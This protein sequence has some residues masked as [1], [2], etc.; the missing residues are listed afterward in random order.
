V[1]PN[2]SS[3]LPRFA[4]NRPVTVVVV[5]FATIVVGLIALK[6][7]PVELF[8][9]GFEAPFL[10]AWT[11]YRD[12]NPQEI[13]E[14]IAK[15]IEEI[16]QTISGLKS[17]ETSSQSQGVWTFLRFNRGTD[18]DVAYAQFRDRMDRVK[19]ELPDGIDRIYLRKFGEN[20]PDI[21]WIVIIIEG[22]VDDPYFLVE[23]Y[24]QRPLLKVDGVASVE[25][26]GAFEK[27]ILIYF[28][29]SKVERHQV[30]LNTVIGKLRTDN[31][32]MSSGFVKDGERK[33]YVRTNSKF[34]SLEAI[35]NIPVKGSN[36]RLSDIADVRYDVPERNWRNR[37][38]G[39]TG[40]S[41]SI[42]KESTANTVAL[43]AAAVKVL[44]EDIIP[45]PA[46]KNLSFNVLFNQ[47]D[48][49]LE[50][51]S[52]LENAAMWGGIFAFLI[53]FFFLRRVRMTLIVTL[54]IPISVMIAMI[55]IYFIDWSLN[56][57]TMMG[58][59]I[60][61][62]MVVDNAIVILEN[63]YR[64][65]TDGSSPR[66]AALFGASEVSLAITMAT[67]TTIAVF[68]PMIVLNSNVGFSFYMLR[69]G[70]P[71]IVA[72]VASLFV[73]LVII[74]LATTKVHSKR[75]VKESRLI[76]WTLGRYENTLRWVMN[77][78]P[79]AV[80]L[81][82]LMLLS[83]D[84]PRNGVK[85]TGDGD[86]NIND[87]RFRFD[88]P[89][90]YTLDQTE[91]FV[92]SVEDSIYARAD[93]YRVKAVNA[94]FRKGWANVNVFLKP[95]EYVNWYETIYKDGM[96]LIGFPVTS[97]LSREEVIEDA[98]KRIPER[99]GIKMYTSWQQ[100]RQGSGMKV[101]VIGDDTNELERLT[102]EIVRRLRT[103]DEIIGVEPDSEE[104]QDEIRL[105]ID[106][107]K[108]A[109]LGIS[110]REVASTVMY[111]LRGF[112]MPKYKTPDK[113]ID[114]RVQLQ[115]SDRQNL[116]QLLDMTFYASNGLPVPLSTFAN[117]TVEK[118]FGSIYRENGKTR[119]GVT[120][121]A[122]KEDMDK[123]HD[124]IKS[125]L[126]GFEMPYGYS[127]SMGQQFR[128]FQDDQD[129]QFTSFLMALI[130]VYLIM[131]ILFESFL[132]PLMI[133]L[134]SVT[135][136][137]FGSFWGLFL[138]GTEANVMAVI[139]IVILIG[140]VVNNGIVL[141]DMII[142]RRKEGFSRTDAIL[143]AGRNRFRPIVMT[144][145]T[146][147]FGLIPMAIGGSGLIGIPYAPMG[148]ALMGGLFTSTFIT[149]VALPL[150]YTLFDD[151]KLWSI[152]FLRYHLNFR[153]FGSETPPE[154]ASVADD[155]PTKTLA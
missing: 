69:I 154:M 109:M 150:L 93:S 46:L 21:L 14:Q 5:L 25:I 132:L 52:N 130:T 153:L 44:N 8:P 74:P 76:Q 149:L 31:F 71:V 114:V 77:N 48:L 78:R 148:R 39:K 94:W 118:G 26:N 63:I 75:K 57:F 134:A 107:E 7:T 13:E 27:E 135:S 90:N 151:F 106:R 113:E 61:I 88:M 18:M 86:G 23:Q 82:L 30:N 137:L 17:Y 140:I 55:S 81:L 50:S 155:D 129:D 73:A 42:K 108:A 43:S 4:L 110:A 87:F 101:L 124:K 33:I 3:L 92:Q 53:L 59:M 83:I 20:D 104:G 12:S 116:T 54:G 10:G 125:A 9:K 85:F 142:Q 102:K 56:L 66:D 72:L 126:A 98:K 47:G 40:I 128:S 89:D 32:L 64:K 65:R 136:A 49:I 19:T 141:V 15:P 68:L 147:I 24:V 138:T 131:G 122:E 127:W 119:L 100:M 103:V 58:L 41:I 67:L 139:G 79:K 144:A 6:D 145:F 11:P 97:G 62:G 34:A 1:Q 105:K 121:T 95:P 36:I 80:I 111:A 91:A 112:D 96:D 84:I 22:D 143:D 133:I 51:I 60:S 35:R 28:D 152:A 99:P 117:F 120:I 146:T 45:N 2:K 123:M 38:N 115:E 16:V 70:L 29:Q 37:I